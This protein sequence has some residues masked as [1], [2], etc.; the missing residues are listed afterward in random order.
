MKTLLTGTGLSLVAAGLLTL[1]PAPSSQAQEIVP[2]SGTPTAATRLPARYGLVRSY[3]GNTLEVRGLDGSFK[4]YTLTPEMAAAMDLGKGE[5]VAFD[6][7]DGGQI[8]QIK[9]PAVE[10]VLEGTVSSIEGELVTVTSLSGESVTTPVP[11]STIERLALAPGKEL[12]VIQY[13]GTWATKICCPPVAAVPETP[14]GGIEL[15]PEP[16][17]GLW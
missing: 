9:P 15:P 8:T 11:Y 7:D 13:Q 14:I 10:S 4:R 3:S 1:I 17:Q 5:L 2:T 6:A 12:M 16:V